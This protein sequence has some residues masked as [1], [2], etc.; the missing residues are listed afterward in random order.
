ME[1]YNRVT[2]VFSSCVSPVS[3]EGVSWSSYNTLLPVH[4]VKYF[5]MFLFCSSSVTLQSA[6][7]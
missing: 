1:C 7:W 5:S 6:A 4:I 2:V 3:H